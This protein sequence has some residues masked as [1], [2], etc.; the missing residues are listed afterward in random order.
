MDTEKRSDLEDLEGR[1]RPLVE[2][3]WCWEISE[4]RWLVKAREEED[5]GVVVVVFCFW[6]GAP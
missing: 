6:R 5:W 2:E 4:E 3:G 1:V